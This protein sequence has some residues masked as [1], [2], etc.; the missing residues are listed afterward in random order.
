MNCL[1]NPE[2][3]P[4][5]D[6][7]IPFFKKE[8]GHNRI[9]AEKTAFKCNRHLS[10]ICFLPYVR[11]VQLQ[12]RIAAGVFG[13]S[14][15]LYV[16]DI[17]V[18]QWKRHSPMSLNYTNDDCEGEFVKVRNRYKF[19]ANYHLAK[20]VVDADFAKST[21]WRKRPFSQQMNLEAVSTRNEEFMRHGCEFI[22]KL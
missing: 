2:W 21:R 12:E 14:E 22:D 17:T 8:G 13:V 5:D 19:K 9:W 11:F 3:T 7:L 10:M 15:F 6:L 1:I 4:T 16:F 18:D 20:A